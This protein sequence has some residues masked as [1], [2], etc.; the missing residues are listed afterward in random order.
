MKSYQKFMCFLHIRCS[1]LFV[2]FFPIEY[3]IFQRAGAFSQPGPL[4]RFSEMSDRNRTCQSGR[5]TLHHDVQPGSTTRRGDV[6]M[7]G[8]TVKKFQMLAVLQLNIEGLTA[9]KMNVL[10]HL[11]VQ[12]EALVI[13]LQQTQCRQ[14]NNT[15]LCTSWVCFKQKAWPCQVCP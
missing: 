5:A 1:R 4:V 9:S 6:A 13:V 15:K 2:F 14:A 7:S 11:A 10:H 12:Y 3:F 8:H